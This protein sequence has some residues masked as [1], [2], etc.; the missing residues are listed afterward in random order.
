[1]KPVAAVPRKRARWSGRIAPLAAFVARLFVCWAA[2]F[3][4]LAFV[5]VV[6]Q[7]AIGA[8]VANLNMS[9]GWVIPDL[10]HAGNQFSTAG[11]SIQIVGECTSL[12]PTILLCGAIVAFPASVGFKV[13]GLVAGSSILWIFN[14]VRV[15]VLLLVLAHRPAVFDLVHIFLWQSVTILLV[16]GLFALWVRFS[17]SKAP[18]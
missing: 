18:A 16:V 12:T 8:T 17:V 4:L 9:L 15:G 3:L 14:I 2:G 11:A 10:A 1:M 7:A 5:P 13:A 6:E